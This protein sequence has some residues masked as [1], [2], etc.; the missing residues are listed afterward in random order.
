[1]S[2][3]SSVASGI[4]RVFGSVSASALAGFP[5]RFPAVPTWYLRRSCGAQRPTIRSGPGK[6]PGSSPAGFRSIRSPLGSAVLPCQSQPS[7]Q[8]SRRQ[9]RRFSG[10]CKH[11]TR[12]PPGVE[13]ASPWV[14]ASS[15]MA[16]VAVSWRPHLSRASFKEVLLVPLTRTAMLSRS[17]GPAALFP[18]HEES[19]I[20]RRC[21]G[22][23][24]CYGAF[25]NLS[26]PPG[27]GHSLFTA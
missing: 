26:G 8:G 21:P 20:S 2:D 10:H 1:M 12:W 18:P 4:R 19:R 23:S 16:A 24:A 14:P 25:V 5:A 15:P 17:S 9:T 13:R 11:A 3:I 7:V 6:A 22:R 27:R